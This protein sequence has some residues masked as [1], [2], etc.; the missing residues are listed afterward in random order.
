V[1]RA[2]LLELHRHWAVALAAREDNGPN[3]RAEPSAEPSPVSPASPAPARAGVR[4]R[5]GPG[6]RGLGGRAMVAGGAIGDRRRAPLRWRH[7]LL[8][9]L[10]TNGETRRPR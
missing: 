6:P 9:R 2:E 5:H 1:N 7:A 8:A 10:L 3:H 4:R